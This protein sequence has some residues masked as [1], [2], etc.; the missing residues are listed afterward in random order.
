[1]DSNRPKL[2]KVTR[3]DSQNGILSIKSKLQADSNIFN[4][5]VRNSLG[6]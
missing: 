4:Y 2:F 6:R 5:I 1:M 3:S